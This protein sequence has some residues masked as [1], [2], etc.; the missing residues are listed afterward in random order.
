MTRNNRKI[1]LHRFW[2]NYRIDMQLSLIKIKMKP[3]GLKN[4]IKMTD[5]DIKVLIDKKIL[6]SYNLIYI[7]RI[8]SILI[9]LNASA[10]Q[11]KFIKLCP[12]KNYN[13]LINLV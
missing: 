7:T 1:S 12:N 9:I 10:I 13:W 6:N 11:N 8:N 5:I 2:D 3:N 4:S